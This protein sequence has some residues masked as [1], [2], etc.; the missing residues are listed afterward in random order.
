MEEYFSPVDVSIVHPELPYASD[1]LCRVMRIFERNGK[2][3]A[4]EK[5][6]IVIIGV[7]DERGAVQNKGC[8]DGPDA[9]REKLYRLKQHHGNVDIIDFGNLIPG[10]TTDDTYA[11]LALITSELYAVKALPL[12]LG[13]SQDLTYGQYCGYKKLEQIINIV[14]IDARFDLG[15]PE[16][17]LN[18]FSWLGKIILEQPN[19]LF[20]FSNLAYQT[21]FVG[22]ESVELMRK[23]YFDTYRVGQ[24][25]TDLTETEPVLRTADLITFDM[26]AIRQSDS[27]GNGN[28]SPNGLTGEEACQIMYYS[29]VSDRL[30]GLGIYDYNPRLDRQQQSSHLVA[31]MIWYFIEGVS[32]RKMDL[33]LNNPNNYITYRV[34]VQNL[35][36][37]IVFLKSIK[38]DRWWMKLPFDPSR[39][40]Y[41]HQHLMP[42]SYKDYQQACN[43]EVPD[44]WWNSLQKLA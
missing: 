12:I 31:Q 36:S 16:D 3:P 41:S 27:P 11:A 38:S 33:P 43:N 21:Y 9:I 5:N 30:S 44:R 25:K 1:D 8:S 28:S 15:K 32:Q 26:S 42:C 10:A 4:A 14:S 37:E 17:E 40:R 18:A 6:T 23:L 39:N 35:E 22:L 2:F 19:Y 20:N 7:P 34:A 24:V 13:G 29:G